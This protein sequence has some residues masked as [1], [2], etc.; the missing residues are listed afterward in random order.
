[1]DWL[2]EKIKIIIFAYI[3]IFLCIWL[4]KGG[5]F[6]VFN[7]LSSPSSTGETLPYMWRE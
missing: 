5:I 4:A 2:L 3:A 6:D 7:F 1:M